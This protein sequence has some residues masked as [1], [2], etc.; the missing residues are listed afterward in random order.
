MIRRDY[1][2]RQIEEFVAAMAKV[3]GLAKQEQWQQ[4][5]TVTSEQFKALAGANADELVQLSDTD[6]LARLVE[7]EPTHVVE[8]KIFMLATLFKAQGD[9]LAGEGKQEES[10][11]YYLKGLHLL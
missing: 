2:L 10:S 6:L 5:A 11:L 4:A 3:A 1:L 7:G 8:N 9:I